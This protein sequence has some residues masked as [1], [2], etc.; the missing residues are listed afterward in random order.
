MSE[1]GFFS[2]EGAVHRLQ[3]RASGDNIQSKMFCAQENQSFYDS[4]TS[5]VF[6]SMSVFTY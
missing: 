5:Q 2:S 4:E 1:L 6:F 3:S